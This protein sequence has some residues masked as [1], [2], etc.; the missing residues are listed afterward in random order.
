MGARCFASSSNV[1]GSNSLLFCRCFVSKQ[2]QTERN[3]RGLIVNNLTVR[4]I[5]L[6]HGL[7]QEAFAERL[8]VSKS[9]IAAIETGRRRVTK[10]VQI[11]IAQKFELTDDLIQAIQRTQE[12]SKLAI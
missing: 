7:S 9:T 5:R 3:E 4:A 8:G 10:N 6:Y 11:K 1:G 12:A 2:I